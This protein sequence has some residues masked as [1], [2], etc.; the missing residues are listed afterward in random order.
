MKDSPLQLWIAIW[1]RRLVRALVVL[2]TLQALSPLP[3]ETPVV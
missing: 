3:W 2:A 1:R